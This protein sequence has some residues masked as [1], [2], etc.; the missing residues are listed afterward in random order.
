MTAKK[1]APVFLALVIAVAVVVATIHFPTPVHR[2]PVLS[3]APARSP[4]ASAAIQ[5]QRPEPQLVRSV[6]VR[7][8]KIIVNVTTADE[9]FEVLHPSDEISD[10][11][12][13][14]GGETVEHS[15]GIEDHI[16]LVTFA[17]NQDS[18]PYMVQSIM[19]RPW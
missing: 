7:G 12:V 18:G 9:A 1:Y 17:R 15:Y 13:V 16:L 14:S 10:P 11:I 5:T 19:T 8:K 4:E 6:T 3:S 2:T